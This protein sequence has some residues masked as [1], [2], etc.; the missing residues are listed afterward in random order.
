MLGNVTESHNQVSHRSLAV[1][2][3]GHRHTQPRRVGALADINIFRLLQLHHLLRLGQQ[4]PLLGPGV[5]GP[6]TVQ[7]GG[8]GILFTRA[9]EAQT[10]FR[11]SAS[12][13]S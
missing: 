1:F 7:S 5:C 11:K 10:W 3:A 2:T 9:E 12:R 4:H 6:G 8:G 13:L